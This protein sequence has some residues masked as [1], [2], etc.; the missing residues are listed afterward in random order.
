VKR[1][2]L[3]LAVLAAGA[4]PLACG[5]NDYCIG[6]PPAT[7]DGGGD[8][9]GSGSDG[10]NGD[11]GTCVPGIEV[12]DNVDNDCDQ[13]VDEAPLPEIGQ[14]CTNQTGECA[15]AVKQCVS[16]TVR[17]SKEPSAETCD[18]KDNNCNGLTDEGNPGGGTAC[19]TD[20]GECVA[21]VQTC[22]SGTVVCVGAVGAGTESCNGR[23][24]DCDALFDEG[25]SNL[26]SCGVTDVGECT[27]GT[28][29][30]LGGGVVCMGATGP[31][32]EICDALDQD[33]DGN[34]TNGFDLMTDP[35]NCGACGNL[36]NLP[37]A[38]E[39]CVGGGCTIA[40]CQS[41]YH[42]NDGMP[43]T[44]CEY[45]PCTIQST[46]E[47]CNGADDNCNQ[48]IDEGVAV[49]SPAA[50]CR[51]I[52]E[53]A[54]GTTVSCDGAA[55]LRCHYA[56]PDVSTDAMGNIVPEVLCDGKDNDC[57]GAID[58]G[59]PNLGQACSSGGVGD[60]AGTGTF[61]C[62]AANRSGPAVCVITQPGPGMSA[63]VCDGRDNNCNGTIDENAATGNLPGQDWVTVPGSAAQIMKYEASRPNATATNVGT[64][65]THVCSR[66]GAQPWT[67][68]TY[69]QAVAA[70]AT[71]GARLC[72]EAEWERMC[73][74]PP[75]YPVAGP[76]DGQFLF[77]EAE[78]ASGNPI[79]AG[80][81]W[82]RIPGPIEDNSGTA[83]M[84]TGDSGVTITN[85][86]AP[87]QSARLD[88]RVNLAANTTYVVWARL[89][90]GGGGSDSVWVGINQT[91]PGTANA[92]QLV[93]GPDSVWGWIAG[94][95]ITTGAAGASY[96]NVYM[97]EDGTTVD[98]IAIAR[99][100][101]G[102]PPFDQRT[103]AY[104]SNT[105]TVQPQTCNGDDYDTTPGGAD[106]D[107]ILPT[108]SLPQ[109]FANGAGTNDAY[110]MSGN[111]KEW[112]AR[113]AAGQNPI[114]GGA[115]NNEAVGLSC[116]LDFTLADDTFFFPNVGFRCCRN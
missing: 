20:V 87:T 35:T 115:S 85:N 68:V 50:F 37:N 59:Q 42:D 13:K 30:C 103:W 54:A 53:C 79:V 32:F 98:G 61:Q 10:G 56:D 26:G 4:L 74:P 108:G 113:R 52:G 91:L 65:Q 15:G 58:E 107:A 11:G 99:G 105:K 44:G 1:A 80:R 109:C 41:G 43:S 49:P 25:L 46:T 29:M 116:S 22:M 40:A 21:G 7:G 3:C 14:Q 93:I 27:L 33:C 96:V 64:Q 2:L 70:C 55:G 102:P 69:P 76:N 89:M 67:N 63:E 17:C 94:P 36:C 72:T 104:Q 92:T 88:F 6:C 16:G 95:P 24:D 101:A 47:V 60:C 110:D 28:R 77:L 82:Q 45:G 34:P 12:C 75:E 86:N 71:V 97:R 111:V 48:M 73:G 81:V 90:G 8:D 78:D 112:T 62:N 106:D 114:R 66:V 9:G 84:V 100:A 83:V 57:D 5:V 51:V 18:N 38:F 39:G 19:G 31:G 23:D